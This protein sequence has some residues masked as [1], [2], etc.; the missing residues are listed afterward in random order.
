MPALASRGQQKHELS[1]SYTS[2]PMC[3]NNNYFPSSLRICLIR[4]A[5]EVDHFHYSVINVCLARGGSGMYQHYYHQVFPVTFLIA[6]HGAPITV[7]QSL[8]TI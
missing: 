7:S 2:V 4:F 8:E 5:I 1:E 6:G 3:L